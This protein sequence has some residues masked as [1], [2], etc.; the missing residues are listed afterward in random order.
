MSVKI[1]NNKEIQN[2][3]RLS[4][5]Q[6]EKKPVKSCLKKLAIVPSKNY[7]R[8]NYSQNF[9]YGFNNI[10]NN[11]KNE[12]S[13]NSESQDTTIQENKEKQLEI[14]IEKYT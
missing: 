11:E 8:T 3:R 1:I 14:L 2:I 5:V 12:F 13:E 10:I 4:S 7:L 6:N 9:D